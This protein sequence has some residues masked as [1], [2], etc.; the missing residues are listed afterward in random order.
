VKSDG[1]AKKV[2]EKEGSVF[3]FGT[4]LEGIEGNKL[5]GM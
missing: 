3:H 4:G 2:V 5:E 1:R